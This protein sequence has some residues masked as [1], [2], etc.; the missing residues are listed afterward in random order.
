MSHKLFSPLSLY[1][2]L[3]LSH[4]LLCRSSAMKLE[5]LSKESD[6]PVLAGLQDRL[7]ELTG[8]LDGRGD[9]LDNMVGKISNLTDNV[10]SLEQWIV[11]VVQNLQGEISGYLQNVR[12]CLVYHL[13]YMMRADE[14]SNLF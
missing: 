14:A 5:A 7:R 11:A 6:D 4:P 2:K 1:L 3:N 8:K 9:K 12:S 10:K 13:S